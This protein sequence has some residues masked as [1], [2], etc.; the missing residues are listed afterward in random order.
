MALTKPAGCFLQLLALP[1]LVVGGAL[2]VSGLGGGGCGPGA[3]GA[4]VALL[5]VVA[6]YFGRQPA[7]R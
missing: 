5:G 6:L 1:L 7:V 3:G 4:V 2:V